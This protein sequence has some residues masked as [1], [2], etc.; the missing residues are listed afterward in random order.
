[1]E[2]FRLEAS[3]FDGTEGSRRHLRELA[4]ANLRGLQ[5]KQRMEVAVACNAIAGNADVTVGPGG[6]VNGLHVPMHTDP[7][8]AAQV[9]VDPDACAR[10]VGGLAGASFTVNYL[11]V[12]S[13]IS[14][15]PGV[16]TTVLEVFPAAAG[17][18]TSFVTDAMNIHVSELDR[19]GG[20]VVCVCSDGDSTHVQKLA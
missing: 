9:I 13:L 20:H 7:A 19:A 10:S 16:P 18:A 8:L 6:T 15:V 12:I 17:K 14:V 5:H 11:R 4:L 1:M 2:V 3:I